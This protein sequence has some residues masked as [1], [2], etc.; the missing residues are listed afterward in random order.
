LERFGDGGNPVSLGNRVSDQ[1]FFL[2]V[3]FWRPH[4]PFLA[5]EPY[6]ERY[7]AG[8][9]TLAADWTPPQ[10]VPAIA[11]HNSRELFGYGGVDR[12]NVDELRQQLWH[13]Y[14]A[15]ISYVDAQ[16]GRVIVA[17]DES[18][19]ADRTVIVL[20]SDHGFHLGQH[21]LWCKTSC[22]ELDARVPLIIIPPKSQHAGSRTRAIVELLDL[23]P[24]L[25]ELCGL[26]A[27]ES[28][29]GRSL[30]PLLE[31]PDTDWPH[32]ALTQHPRPAY[33]KGKPEA[34]GYSLRTD[35]YRYI[36][37]CHWQTGEVVARELY[38]H[39]IDADETMNVADDPAYSTVVLDHQHAL[40]EHR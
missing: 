6:W 30:V 35:R 3:G 1:P 14:Y 23:Y 19:L 29:E 18:G 5:P 20:W 8:S 16:I 17:L 13:G 7:D 21:G 39:E 32:A 26:D 4:L 36:E 22:F 11:L 27:P 28:L 2:A 10:N 24:T 31:D 38:D 15:G 33:Y 9:L 34:M 40:G 12:D 25:A 37:W